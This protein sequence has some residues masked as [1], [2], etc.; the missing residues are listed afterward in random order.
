MDVSNQDGEDMTYKIAIC[1]DSGADRQYVLN[2]VHAWAKVA[3]HVVHTDTF[4]SAENFLF[5]YAEESDYDILL[6]DIEMGAMDGVSLAKR[7][8][9]G[10]ESV[11]IVFITGFADYISE[12][13]EVAALHYLMKPV[14]QD[15]LFAVLDRAA[16]AVQKT[17]QMILLPMGGEML[18]LPIGQVQYVEAFSHTVAIVTGNDTIQVKMPISEVEK[19]LGE[20]VIRCHRSYLVGLKHIARLSKTE[21]T[22]DSG[23]V[24]PLS[25][26]A[27]PLVHKAFISYY[28]GERDETV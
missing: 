13:Y 18:R 10:N 21:V 26:S 24:L 16:A 14:K 12:G 1:D 17:E 9:Q 15:K 6:L 7:I 27:A 20:G 2:M 28:T 25:R 22:L 3:G 11:Q 5:R 19:L 4:L 23:K 8:R